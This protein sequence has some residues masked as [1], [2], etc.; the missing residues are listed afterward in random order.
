MLQSRTRA[1]RKQTKKHADF[2]IPFLPPRAL[3][4]C[5]VIEKCGTTYS[6][7]STPEAAREVFYGNDWG[8]L[9]GLGEGKNL[10]DCATL[11]V[12]VSE[13]YPTGPPSHVHVDGWVWVNLTGENDVIFV[14]RKLHDT[15]IFLLSLVR[16]YRSL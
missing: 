2:G 15:K 8:V 6:M 11:R 14:S 4:P 9:A 5:K 7:L 10:V 3:P 12:N 16:M 13:K 1:T